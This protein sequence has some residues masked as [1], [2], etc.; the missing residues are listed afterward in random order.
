MDVSEPKIV[1]PRQQIIA[2]RA[3]TP[4]GANDPLFA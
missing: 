3:G 1:A 4:T 2:P